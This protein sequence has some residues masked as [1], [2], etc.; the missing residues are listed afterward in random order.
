MKTSRSFPFSILPNLPL[1]A[2]AIASLTA[3]VRAAGPAD[4]VVPLQGSDSNGSFSHGN[5]YPSVSLPFAMNA[6]SPYTQPCKDS[7]F[8]QYREPKLRGLRQTHQP[9]P[10]IGD[11]G[12]FSI[13]PVS[14]NLVCDEDGRASGFSH[15]N[16][17]AH[18]YSYKVLLEK[19]GVTAELAPTAHCASFRISYPQ[20]KD[21][22]LVIDGFP[23]GSTIEVQPE[24]NRI[25]GTARNNRGGVP[26]GFGNH[27]IIQF[28][29]P[30]QAQGT[31]KPGAKPTEDL[32]ADGDHTGAWVKVSPADGPVTFTAVSSFIDHAQA[33]TTLSLEIGKKPFEEVKQE[34]KDRWNEMLGR[35]EIEGGLPDQQ[36]TFYTAFYRT[37][38]FPHN[39]AEPLVGGGSRYFSPYDGKVHDGEMFTDSGFWDTFRAV[40]PLFNLVFPEVNA[41]I[42]QGMLAASDQSGWLPAWASPGH[43]DCMIG[44][45]S[46]S[47]FADAWVKGVRDFDA[48]KAVAAMLHDSSQ[49][50]PLSSIGRLGAKP[51]LEKGYVPAPDVRESAAR[52]LEYA[53]NDFCAAQIA[54]D[55]G[56]DEAAET[57][58]KRSANY[59]NLFDPTVKFIRG[60]RADG[61]WLPDFDPAEWGGPFTEGCSWHWTWCVFHDVR[62]LIG[63]IGGDKAFTDKLDSVFQAEPRVNVGS[64]GGM[65]HEMSEMVAANMGQYAHGNQPIQHMI[66]LYGYA[67]QPWKTQIHAREVMDRLYFPTPDGLCGDEDNGQTSAWYV[68]SA[69]GMYPVCPGTPEYVIGSP[70]FDKATVH[71]PNGKTFVVN[72]ENNGP[73]RPYIQSATLGGEPFN[74]CF[75]THDEITSGGQVTFRMDSYKNEKWAADEAARPFSESRK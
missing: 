5:N 16:E 73:L 74:R 14:G 32:K 75:L 57:F 65:I 21:G 42:L 28:D 19:W 2:L 50:G 54:K 60:K 59:K 64:Y 40:H 6:W 46:F 68:F 4:L 7:F 62:G 22:Y 61:S 8:Y 41:K 58:G 35:I 39:L 72:T 17:E 10:W 69:L 1:A 33:E 70:L 12:A 11:Y 56:M 9:S 29:R 27:F 45:N 37:M 66:Y 34:A 15:S 55:I 48:K 26:P 25:V 67:G 31:W 18:P 24:K 3:P 23:G 36:R 43:R 49:E 38:L 63:L 20:D 44:N 52:T 53:Y 51:Y 71:L 47:L 13:M 30:F